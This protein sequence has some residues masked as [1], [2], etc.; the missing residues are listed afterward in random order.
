MME[1]VAVEM[2]GEMV[3]PASRVSCPSKLYAKRFCEF[4][5]LRDVSYR[6]V[7]LGTVIPLEIGLAFIDLLWW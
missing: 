2:A 7:F 3:R 5:C 6:Y 1:M 4:N